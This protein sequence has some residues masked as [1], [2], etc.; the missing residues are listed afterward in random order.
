MKDQG[1]CSRKMPGKPA[2]KKKFRVVD[3]HVWGGELKLFVIGGERPS[4]RGLPLD[5]GVPPPHIGQPYIISDC[6][7]I[8]VPIP[9]YPL[10][11]S[12]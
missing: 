12:V 6:I 10:F 1:T 11:I 8:L 5:V 9:D 7:E 3:K 2:K 4:W